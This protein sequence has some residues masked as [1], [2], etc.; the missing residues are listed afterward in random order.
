[1]RGGFAARLDPTLDEISDIKAA[2]SEAV[3]KAVVH[4]YSGKDGA[5]VVSGSIEGRRVTFSIED[6]GVGIDD[7]EQARRPFF[8]TCEGEDRSGMGFTM[9][10]AFMDSVTVESKPGS[11]TKVTMTKLIGEGGDGAPHA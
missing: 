3:T 9:M 11:G 5:I 1:M 7:I 2:I 10:E 4:G 6:R 8:T